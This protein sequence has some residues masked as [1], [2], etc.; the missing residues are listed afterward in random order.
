VVLAQ[1]VDGAVQVV[2]FD[3]KAGEVATVSVRGGPELAH[4]RS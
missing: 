1:L 4:S 3:R 2:Q